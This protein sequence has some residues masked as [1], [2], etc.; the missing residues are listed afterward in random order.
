M[1]VLETYLLISSL[2]CFR[3]WNSNA[4]AISP[5]YL[6]LG[7]LLGTLRTADTA[8]D[9]QLYLFFVTVVNKHSMTFDRNSISLNQTV[10][11]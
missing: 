3:G 5:H 2:C 1:L 9:G 10:G 8:A 7:D 11:H 6:K 4:T